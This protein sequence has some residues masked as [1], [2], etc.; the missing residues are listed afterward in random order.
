MRRVDLLW[1]NDHQSTIH[2]KQ[3]FCIMLVYIIHI[4]ALTKYLLTWLRESSIKTSPSYGNLQTT[5]I[6]SL[7]DA[8]S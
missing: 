3:G 6:L 1:G 2:Q 4:I 5:L 7:N 8:G